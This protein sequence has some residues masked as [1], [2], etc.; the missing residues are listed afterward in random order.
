[1]TTELDDRSL[2]TGRRHSSQRAG[3]DSHGNP[4]TGDADAIALYDHAIDRLVRFHPDVLDAAAQLAEPERAL[5]MGWVMIAY[6]SLM[7]TE[8]GDLA[9]ARDALAAL[10]STAGDERE[11]AHAQ[12]IE[13]WSSGDWIGAADTLDELLIRWPS[14]LLA[15]MFGHQLD[16]FVGDAARLRDRAV[17]AVHEFDAGHPHAGFV[18][19]I[20]A[21]GL[22]ESGHFQHAIDSGMAAIDAH[23]D[24]VWAIHAVVHAYEMQGRI[25]EGVELL[26]SERTRWERDNLFTVH[27]WWHLALYE[28][29][30]G[31]VDRVLAIYDS[32]VHNANSA[33]IALEMLDAS[34]LLWRLHLDGADVGD[35]WAPLADAWA[36]KTA[37]DRWYV[38]NDVHA[39]EALVGAGRVSD[40]RA[41]VDAMAASA[42]AATDWNSQI[43]REVGI[44][45]C[46]ALIAF[47]EGRHDQVVTTLYPLRRAFQR[48]GGSHAQRDAMQRTLLESA[49]RSGQFRLARALTAERLAVRETGVYSWTQRARALRG[50]GD[51]VGA[52]EAD[53]KARTFREAMTPRI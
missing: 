16:F 41:F 30:L 40:A 11:H 19:G 20:A 53:A 4:I 8:P 42:A 32:E 35:R 25:T 7:S 17:R 47:G 34:A 23:A 52:H 48:F 5:P 27:N 45:V 43:S 14:D 36:P 50:L 31:R 18:R 51:A 12:A 28:L 13:R 44:P 2:T 6:L 24:D 33:C 22:E 46:E 10:R 37:A 26:R 15:L 29:E 49:L 21:F 39:V 9:A 38:F 1:M 3:V